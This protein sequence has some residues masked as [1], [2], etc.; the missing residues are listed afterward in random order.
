[1]E[2][3][4]STF[5]AFLLVGGPTLS[6][7]AFAA[8]AWTM[9]DVQ[10]LAA[11]KSWKELLAGADS[12]PPSARTPEWAPLVSQA[13]SN[14]LQELGA[15]PSTEAQ[16]TGV[17]EA[18]VK[19]EEKYPFL[20]K[21]ADYLNRKSSSLVSLVA[22][23]D[24]SRAWGCGSV[25]EAISRGLQSFPKGMAGKI[26]LLMGDDGH[27]PSQTLRFWAMAAREDTSSCAFGALQSGAMTALQGDPKGDVAKTGVTVASA[28]YEPWETGL[29]DQLHKESK[30]D[31]YA[32]NVCPILKGHGKSTMIM[33]DKCP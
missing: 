13:A 3:L 1:M 26:A 6:Q 18:V 29:L 19:A 27:F 21:D 2:Q 9:K 12:V 4:A 10:A 32:Q 31:A 33:R 14:R 24:R 25:L 11:A 17:I 8:P 30:G 23:C 22:F 5:V 20:L 16:A 15:E 7:T 28:C